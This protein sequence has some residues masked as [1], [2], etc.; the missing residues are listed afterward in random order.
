M[1][2]YDPYDAA[3]WKEKCEHLENQLR[4]LGDSA[5]TRTAFDGM[6]SRLAE[7]NIE[8]ERLKEE[9]AAKEQEIQ[10]E[11][12]F[13]LCVELDIQMDGGAVPASAAAILNAIRSEVNALS[14]D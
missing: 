12:L 6:T 14:R 7:A 5:V 8:I 2:G 1:T 10:L 9:N 3:P 11:R 4:L 13:R